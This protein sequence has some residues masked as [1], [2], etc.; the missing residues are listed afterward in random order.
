MFD[1]LR[2]K[3]AERRRGKAQSEAGQPAEAP[4][5]PGHQHDDRRARDLPDPIGDFN[6]IERMGPVISPPSGP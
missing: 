3:R 1:R 5:D 2:K 6:E 4:P